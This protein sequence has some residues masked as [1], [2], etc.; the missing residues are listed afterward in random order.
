M[1]LLFVVSGISINYYWNSQG[2]KPGVVETGT[3]LFLLPF[4]IKAR[5]Y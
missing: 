5:M 4:F 1:A 3:E 2:R